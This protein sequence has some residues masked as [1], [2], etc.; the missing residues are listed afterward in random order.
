MNDI[1]VKIGADITNFSRNM[2][3]AINEMKGLDK[4]AH[5]ST[6]TL[7]KLATSVGL[8][9]VAAKGFQM[10]KSSITQAFNRIDTMEQFERVMTT[11]TGSSE[12]A[13]QV[14]DDVNGIVKGTAYG[15]DVAA[16]STQDF[17]TSGMDV[18]KATDSIESWG[19]A[20]A[21][22]GNGSN[23]SFASVTDALAKMTAKGKVQ[24]DTMNRLTEAGIPAMQIYADATNQSVE[25]VAETMQKGGLDAEEFMDVMND[26]LKNGTTNFDGIAGAA[27]EAG[28]SWGASFDNMRAAVARGVTEIIESIDEMLANNGLPSMRDMV[29][30]FG[31]KFE[32]VLKSLAQ[33]IPEIVEKIQDF[34]SKLRE[35]WDRL[36]PIQPVLIA[37]AQAIGITVGA[38]MLFNT[39]V[40]IVN[41]VRRAVELM[42]LALLFNPW[43]LA[44]TAAV[45]AVLLI[46]HYWEPISEFF[47]N[48]WEKV[49]EISISVWDSLKGAWDSAVEFFKNLWNGTVEFFVNI[50]SGV[51]EFFVNLWETIKQAGISVWDGLVEKWN[52]M[53][54]LFTVLW[55][56]VSLFFTELWESLK[57][58]AISI[59]DTVTEKWNEVVSVI[60]EVFSPMIDFFRETFQS[61]KD[62]VTENAQLMGDML[63][64]VW[65]NIKIIASNMWE[66]IK[67]VILGPILLLINLVTGDMDEFKSNLSSIWENIKQA[68]SKIWN[69]LKDNVLK[70]IDTFIEMGKNVWE[71]FKE[72]LRNLWTSIRDTA[73]NLWNA[74]KTA[75]IEIAKNLA[76]SAID[77]WNNLKETTARVFANL[78]N[79]AK[80]KWQDLKD[81]V[82]R[83]V[84]DL[85]NNVK[86]KWED[87]KSSVVNTVSNLISDVK[88]KWQEL[89][90]SVVDLV[91]GFVNDILQKWEEMKTKTLDKIKGVKDNVI[92]PLKEIDLLQ[93]G[94]DI[95][96]GLINGIRNKINDVK[97]AIKDVTDSIT[98][99]IKSILNINSPSKV[100]EQYGIWTGGGLENGIEKSV[101]GVAKAA[102]SM[103]KAAVPNI[104]MSYA[105]P[106]G[107]QGSLSSAVNGTV[108]VNSNARDRALIGAINGLRRD[109]SNMRVEMDG[110]PVGRITRPY[111]NEGNAKDEVGR[112]FG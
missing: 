84:L 14:L 1:L 108:S 36:E 52:E 97:N 43:V 107:L 46:I 110:E 76:Q 104:D 77:R 8:V 111:I 39:V 18:D 90:S 9:A 47:M 38:F 67:N 89:K 49:K 64:T 44:A 16:K 27:K 82:V 68:A 70:V 81:S 33:K 98:G 30:E 10:L 99:K 74:L 86:Q 34:A 73:K 96:S 102:D 57:E 59:W 40:G 51:S 21:F 22:Y 71:M 109:M 95:I 35:L 69:A 53:T 63:S 32:D 5:Q 100:L 37:I 62:T 26:A 85:Y 12:K 61:I 112:Y 24:M 20:V 83:F 25:E 13:G 6:L 75:V 66:I 29:A 48:L 93:I 58:T 50:W 72:Y 106:A 87:L 92:N 56:T 42:N 45:A 41:A 31:S 17:V 55:S 80:Q 103:A 19:D 60:V 91:T 23:E 4:G 54:T 2:K 78:V 3:N 15:L 105:T 65:E 94:K 7:G 28:A 11:M 101:K 88:Q 79:T